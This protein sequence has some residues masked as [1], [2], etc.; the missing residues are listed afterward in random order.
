MWGIMKVYFGNDMIFKVI[1]TVMILVM[2]VNSVNENA[3]RSRDISELKASIQ[4]R[5]SVIMCKL[6]RIEMHITNSDEIRHDTYMD[7]KNT[8]W[9]GN[10]D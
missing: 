5:D 10:V 3:T 7:T 1:V 4:E 2:T 9:L 6:S 8:A